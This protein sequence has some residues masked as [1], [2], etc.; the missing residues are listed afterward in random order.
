MLLTNAREGLFQE[1]WIFIHQSFE[2]DRNL[3]LLVDFNVEPVALGEE[4]IAVS[5]QNHIGGSDEKVDI[6]S[7]RA[8]QYLG[9]SFIQLPFFHRL[10]SCSKST[11]SSNVGF[12]AIFAGSS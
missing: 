12:A 3:L 5:S 6:N 10:V 11:S 2:Y 9:A 8:H 1:F 7:K 4:T